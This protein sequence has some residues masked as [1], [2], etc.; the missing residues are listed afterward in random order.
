MKNPFNTLKIQAHLILLNT[1]TFNILKCQYT[2][3]TFNT[4]KYKY[5]K[6]T[7]YTAKYE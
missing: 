4:L 6:N 1:N 7:F 2:K 5:T 3:N